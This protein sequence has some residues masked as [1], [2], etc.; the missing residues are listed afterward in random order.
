MGVEFGGEG[1][2]PVEIYSLM[3][4]CLDLHFQPHVYQYCIFG[5][6]SLHQ[7]TSHLAEGLDAQ[8][9]RGHPEGGREVVEVW[10][11]A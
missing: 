8:E 5:D 2:E 4:V 7:L 1:A 9:I 11:H 10:R 6:P 3:S